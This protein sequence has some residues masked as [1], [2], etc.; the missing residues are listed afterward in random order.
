MDIFKL[1]SMA[2]LTENAQSLLTAGSASMGCACSC[3]CSC[4]CD[5][6]SGNSHT[7]SGHTRKADKLTSAMNK[8]AG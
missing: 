1:K 7:L 2:E 4:Y 3:S 5:R 8:Q 6:E